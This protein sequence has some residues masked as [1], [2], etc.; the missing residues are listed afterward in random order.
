MEYWKGLNQHLGGDNYYNYLNHGYHPPYKNLFGYH[1]IFKHQ[2][3]LYL[4]LFDDIDTKNK[5]LLEVGCGR[6]GGINLL[7]QMFD[8]KNIEACDLSEA[9]INHC[10]KHADG[11]RFKVAD[12]ENLDYENNQFDIVISVESTCYYKEPA[13]FYSKV[14][15]LLKPN[16]VFLY[17]DIIEPQNI[18]YV[19][20]QLPLY[21]KNI[22]KENITPNVI[23]AC[24]HDIIHFDKVIS[25]EDIKESYIDIAK[26][27]GKHYKKGEIVYFKY[28]CNQEII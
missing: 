12:A 9:N 19:E 15:K 22:K 8:F 24:D 17:T 28:V 18:T 20:T 2:A 11:I 7:S 14:Q 26:I 23:Q 27:K 10:Q 5:S 3:S 25:D 6:G 21:F 16:G 13:R 4:H 1:K